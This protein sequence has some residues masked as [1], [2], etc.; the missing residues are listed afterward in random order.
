MTARKVPFFYHEMV[1]KVALTNALPPQTHGLTTSRCAPSTTPTSTSKT[2]WY[3]TWAMQVGGAERMAVVHN[4]VLYYWGGA[5]T[6]KDKQ[7]DRLV[8]VL[9]QFWWKSMILGLDKWFSMADI[10][11]SYTTEDNQ[12]WHVIEEI[13]AEYIGTNGILVCASV[14]ADRHDILANSVT[15]MCK[16]C[17]IVTCQVIFSGRYQYNK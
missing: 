7:T 2:H 13:Y 9:N 6:Q 1:H 8:I 10:R 5:Q 14:Y 11:W 15:T 4:I 12:I 16:I 3:T 17:H